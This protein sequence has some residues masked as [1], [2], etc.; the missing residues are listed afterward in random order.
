[1]NE[2]GLDTTLNTYPTL[3][4]R[5]LKFQRITKYIVGF[6]IILILT[7]VT[8][9][10]NALPLI[11]VKCLV[12]NIFLWTGPINSFFISHQTLKKVFIG[13]LAG[14]MDLALLT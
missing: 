5:T 11:H 10:E 14:L 7:Y 12:D 2:A 3:E 1:V 8:T 6:L 9:N 4:E 13:I